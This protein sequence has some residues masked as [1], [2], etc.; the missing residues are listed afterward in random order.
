MHVADEELLHQKSRQLCQPINSLIA[1]ST[2]SISAGAR[3]RPAP[4]PQ[5]L[6]IS[7]YSALTEL[8]KKKYPDLANQFYEIANTLY[9][10][11]IISLSKTKKITYQEAEK[12]FFDNVSNLTDQYIDEMNKNGKLNG[13]Y[14]KDSF[15]ADDLSFCHE[16]TRHLQ[17]VIMESLRE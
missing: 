9:P 1:W 12:Y 13:S 15:L 3:P 7:L 17:L 16:V 2:N 6:G 10:Y 11:G 14:F 5:M 8:I 4:C